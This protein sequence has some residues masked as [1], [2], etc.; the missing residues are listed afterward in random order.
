MISFSL[1]KCARKRKD[2]PFDFECFFILFYF[3]REERRLKVCLG[4]DVVH[5]YGSP[6]GFY[7]VQLSRS[8]LFTLFI[9]SPRLFLLSSLVM[10]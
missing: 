9:L 5:N 7:V 3:F 2:S 4:S 8:S 10:F 1:V 6:M